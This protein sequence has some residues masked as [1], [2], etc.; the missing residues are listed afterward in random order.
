MFNAF[1]EFLGADAPPNKVQ[2]IKTDDYGSR[3]VHMRDENM[4]LYGPV[5]NSGHKKA[6]YEI[7]LH[8]PYTEQANVLAY[9][10]Y[11]SQ[12]NKEVEEKFNLLFQRLPHFI[13]I[14]KEMYNLNGLQKICDALI[15][16]PSWSLTHLV[17]YFNLTQYL[18]H[19]KILENVDY[20]DHITHM[21]PLQLAIKSNNTEMVQALLP[22]CKLDHLDINKN[23]VYHFAASTTAVMINLLA[24]QNLSTLNQLNSDGYTPLHLACSKDK[25]D[26]VTALLLAGAD[27]NVTAKLHK[28][29]TVNANLQPSNKPK[30]FVAD[31]LKSNKNEIFSEDMKFGGTPLHWSSSRKVVTQL[32]QRNCDVNALNFN[33]QTALHV[34]VNRERLECVMCLLSHEALIDLK[35]NHGKTPLHIAIERENIAI[36]QA[37]IV[38]GCD[39]NMSNHDGNTPRH[40]VG[41][42]ANGSNADMILFI[43]DSVGANRCPA[44]NVNCPPGC[45]ATGTYNGIPPAEFENMDTRDQIQNVLQSTSKNRTESIM[46]AVYSLKPKEKVHLVDTKDEE[47]GASVMHSMMSLFASNVQSASKN[48]TSTNSQTSNGKGRLLCLD[49]GGIRGLILVQ[50]LLEI[51]KLSQTPINHMFD[52]IAGTSTGGILALGLGCGKTMMECMCLYLRMKEIAF[53]G[54]RPYPSEPLE[55]VLKSCLGEFTVMTDI[56]SP[57]IM[58]TGVMA[59]RKPV[60]L[61]LFRN[62]TSASEILGIVTPT[63]N[64]RDPPPPPDQQLLWRAARASGAAP[65]YFRAFGHFI[66]GGLIA[67]N[68][69]LDAI[70]EIHEYNMALTSVGREKEV[71]PISVVV[72]LGT[73]LIPVTEMKEIDIFRP[74]SIWDTAKLAHSISAIG[75]LLID[76]ATASNGRVVDRARAWC[77]MIGVPF[78]RLNPQMSVD[79]VM[80]ETN[81]EV[82]VNMLWEA[83]AYMYAN[84]QT[85]MDIISIL[86]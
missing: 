74:D 20:P 45:N 19:P 68:P 76:Q 81:D 40:M 55:E 16:N 35:D 37:L 7:V 60:D 6:F 66:D 42:D 73:G 47:S 78:Y 21:T 25:P 13:E 53:I 43:L 70:T 51:E 30:S 2:E 57:K 52:W 63:S 32:I 29:N 49:G 34:M 46:S 9:S 80:D 22:L 72:S 5:A 44:S 48:E 27:V 17:A 33:Q 15:E 85:V 39:I 59:D 64:R 54:S 23:S 18:M 38:F 3:S 50:L 62:Y 4:I 69:T 26:C 28:Q 14:A 10:L 71:V 31:L 82:L 8:R 83:K 56:E 77:S 24:A 41:K 58:V 84:R 67:N 65:S 61:H 11:R 79:V 36:V 1:L 12:S 86:N 75:N